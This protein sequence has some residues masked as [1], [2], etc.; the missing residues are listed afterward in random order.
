MV[1]R[2]KK[3]RNERNQSSKKR[4][5]LKPFESIYI[6]RAPSLNSECFARQ[7]HH[8]SSFRYARLFQTVTTRF[9]FQT[10][11]N[12]TLGNDLAADEPGYTFGPVFFASWVAL[13]N[14]SC[15]WRAS[16]GIGEAGWLGLP[17]PLQ[18]Q[19]ILWPAQWWGKTIRETGRLHPQTW[20]E[21]PF[22]VSQL[23]ERHHKN[24]C[25]KITMMSFRNGALKRSSEDKSQGLNNNSREPSLIIENKPHFPGCLPSFK[26]KI[27][28][29]RSCET[30]I[31]CI[32]KFPLCLKI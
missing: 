11:E 26:M 19:R 4:G 24:G 9:G 22:E 7:E 13:E 27:F 28:L 25:L 15:Y 20:W 8:C 14:K 18:S 16:L 29:W 23:Q 17:F 6:S 1:W 31:M 2:W 21:M 30:D 3:L 5:V 12:C 32:N 10:T